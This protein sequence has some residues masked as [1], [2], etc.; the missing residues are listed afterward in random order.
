MDPVA[1]LK[2]QRELAEGIAT[3]GGAIEI[4]ETGKPKRALWDYAYELAELVQALD[5]WRICGGFDPYASERET[6]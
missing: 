1:N 4:C 5:E 2:R 6:N 3:L